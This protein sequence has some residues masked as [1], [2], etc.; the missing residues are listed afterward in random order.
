MTMIRK[1]RVKVQ[2]KAVCGSYSTDALRRIV[3]LP[4]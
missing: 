2:V 4:K 3:L 1:T